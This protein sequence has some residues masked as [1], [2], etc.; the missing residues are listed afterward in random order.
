MGVVQCC[1]QSLD[2]ICTW[3]HYLD[4]WY[5]EQTSFHNHRDR[6]ELFLQTQWL[7]NVLCVWTGDQTSM[8]VIWVSDVMV[9][10]CVTVMIVLTELCQPIQDWVPGWNCGFIHHDKRCPW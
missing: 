2:G 3:L 8:V 6:C 9:L 4:H 1:D 10:L 5:C 7:F